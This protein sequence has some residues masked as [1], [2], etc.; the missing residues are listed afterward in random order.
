MSRNIPAPP[1]LPFTLLLMIVGSGLIVL[2]SFLNF[3]NE[4][5]VELLWARDVPSD[6]RGPFE[7][8]ATRGLDSDQGVAVLVFGLA[9]V[10]LTAATAFTS[11]RLPLGL[12]VALMLFLAAGLIDTAADIKRIGDEAVSYFS[13][14]G[15]WLFNYRRDYTPGPF[16]LIGEGVWT[17]GVGAGLVFIGAVAGLVTLTNYRRAVEAAR[18]EEP[19]SASSIQAAILQ[20]SAFESQKPYPPANAT[21]G[22]PVAARLE[23]SQGIP[24]SPL[25]DAFVARLRDSRAVRASP[26][27]QVLLEAGGNWYRVDFAWRDEMLV[28]ELDGSQHLEPAHA[29]ADRERDANLR[30]AGWRVLR[31]TWNDVHER[32]GDVEHQLLEAGAP[33]RVS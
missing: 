29:E 15:D 33:P 8:V 25:E 22:R 3:N 12:S 28:V 31:F 14:H 2:G 1:G 4:I 20:P 7:L 21:S 24:E 30:S 19:T 17:S 27:P 26:L 5:R 11:S 10:G 6:Y 18:P 16:D 9:A 32:W 13:Q 23:Q